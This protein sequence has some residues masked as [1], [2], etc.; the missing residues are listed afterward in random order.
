[1]GPLGTRPRGTPHSR[2][3]AVLGTLGSSRA[4]PA[5][6]APN[7]PPSPFPARLQRT[8][9]AKAA[10]LT[11]RRLDFLSPTSSLH[12]VCHPELHKCGTHRS[13]GVLDVAASHQ[14]QVS[15]T[16]GGDIQPG[17][18]RT[19]APTPARRVPPSSGLPGVS[20]IQK[21]SKSKRLR[22][23]S[24]R[25]PAGSSLRCGRGKGADEEGPSVWCA[26]FSRLL[27]RTGDVPSCHPVSPSANHST[28]SGSS[29]G[30]RGTRFLA[31]SLSFIVALSLTGGVKGGCK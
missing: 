17:F 1:M 7:V 21:F 16:L 30:E 11:L 4:L 3:P 14:E 6:P 31:Q 28:D 2:P 19:A 29:S 25:R 12:P 9:D 5:S 15:Q 8:R 26:S 18:R 10:F 23:L 27:P 20:M 24:H 13:A 22:A